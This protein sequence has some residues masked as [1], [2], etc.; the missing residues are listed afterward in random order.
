MLLSLVARAQLETSQWYFGDQAGLDFRAGAPV[1]LTNGKL[2][3]AEGCSSRADSLGNLLFYTNGVTVWNRRHE[4]MMGGADLWGNTST[5]Q[6]LIVA[7]PGRRGMYYLLSPDEINQGAGFRYSVVD[8]RR[9][10][11]LGEVVRRDVLLHPSSTERVAAVP[12]ANGR[13]LWI[14]GHEQ[15]T[16]VCFAYLLTDQGLVSPPVLSRDALAPRSVQVVGQLKASP[17]GRRLALA[18]GTINPQ[19]LAGIPSI[20]LLDFDPATGRISNPVVLPPARIASYGLEFSPGGRLLYVSDPFFGLIHQYDLTAVDVAAS[21]VPIPPPAGPGQSGG[22]P[23]ALQLGPDGRIYVSLSN[24]SVTHIGVITAPDQ[25]GPACDYL[26]LGVD[27]AGRRPMLGLPS[28]MQRDL[29]HFTVQGL[30]QGSPV[31][32]TLPTS[33]GADSIRWHFGDAASGPRDEATGPAPTHVY[34]AP[35]RYLVT[36]I[37]YLPGEVSPAVLRRYVDILPRPTVDL[38][39]DTALCPG[40]TLLLTAPPAAAYRWHDG[41]TAPTLKAKAPGWYWV[42][43]TNATGCTAR[44]SLFLRVL[45]LPLAYL[46]PDTVLCVGQPLRLKPRGAALVGTRYRWSD[47]STG[48]SLTVRTADTYWLEAT[49]AAGCSQRDSIRVFYLTPPTIYLGPDTTLCQNPEQPFQ[50]V[51]T[52]PGVRY[53][54]SDGSTVPTLT[55]TSSGIYWVTVSTAVCSATDSIR[56]RLLDCRQQVFVPNI[57][58][59]NGDGLNDRLEITGLGTT[60]WALTIYSRWGQPVYTTDHYRQDWA[61]TGLAPGTYYYLLEEEEHGRRLKGWIQVTR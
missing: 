10:S 33:Y 44:D 8:M 51:A 58:T 3:S 35:G 52:L 30:C 4:V 54:W 6:Y 21:A 5:T 25:R 23:A 9:Q 34:A 22:T 1:P 31:S 24:T 18:I 55:P 46:G 45:P 48:E 19:Q 16:N 43:I 32:F 11:G 37:L 27:L 13:D 61:A 41:S 15:T 42:E 36:A 56:V 29:W 39:P 59:P 40:Q 38:G 26:P 28:F 49:S 7:Q 12:H 53:R 50:L 47:G 2:Y 20:E 57:I 14:I 17:D 60:T